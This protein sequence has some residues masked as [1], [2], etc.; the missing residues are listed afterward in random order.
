MRDLLD[1]A[2]LSRYAGQFVWLEMNYDAPVNRPFMTKF[3]PQA[4]P[5][6][7]VIDPDDEQVTA[8]QPGAMSLDA[9]KEFLERGANGMLAKNQTPAEAALM[10]GD[11]FRAQQPAEAAKA[12]EEALR[13]APEKWAGRDL[14]EASLVGALQDSAQW[15]QCA[16]KAS[17][18]A[19]GMTRSETF[20]RV[21]VTGMWCVVSSDAAPWVEPAAKKLEPLAT[22]ALSL[23]TTVRDHRDE[24]YRTLMY[25]S[26]A[27]KDNVAAAKW[28]DRWLSELDA[29]HPSSDD[30]RSALDIARVENVQV[31]GDPE[32]ILPALKAS[33][34]A[35]PG[36]YI[37]SLRLAQME[38]AAQHYDDAYEACTRGLARDPGANG[39]AW[40]QQIQAQV[41]IKRG[42][43][44]D[45]RT[46]LQDALETAR[47]IPDNM[48]RDMSMGMIE[49]T[50]KSIETAPK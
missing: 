43:I 9:L 25:L 2:D 16:E 21:V 48:G 45:A 31:Y 4:T 8:T 33:E 40:L 14:A 42:K 13:L 19:A 1:H 24:L 26:V 3:G 20:S 29:I 49:N 34:R 10:R 37:A 12:Y 18:E 17:S 32:R 46:L 11:T 41:L 47:S 28:G 15:Q 38:L 50:L 27:R 30:E 36:N 35:M 39:R 7:F 44:A 22:E 5:T 23:K 6:F